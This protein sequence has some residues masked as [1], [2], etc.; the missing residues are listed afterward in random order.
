MVELL[1]KSRVYKIFR[2]YIDFCTRFSFRKIETVGPPPA[3]DGAVVI[4]SNHTNTL[5]DPLVI[6]LPFPDGIVFGARADVFRRPGLA[7]FFHNIKMVPLAR[8]ERELPEEVARNVQTFGEIDKALAH[9]IPFC[10]FP[11]GRHRTMHSLQPMRRGVAGIAF[12]SAAQRPTAIMPVGL[13]YS[14]WFHY[15]GVVRVWYGPLIDVNALA[16]SIAAGEID[17]DGRTAESA[18]DACLQQLLYDKLSELIFFLPDDD[19]YEDRLAEVTAAK[20]LR[21]KFWRILQAIIGFPLFA[22]CAVLSLPMWVPAE[23]LCRWKIKDP[24]FQNTARFGVKMI[25]TP[26]FLIIWAVVFFLLLPWWAAAALLVLFIH[27]Y[28][29]FYDWTGLIRSLRRG[30]GIPLWK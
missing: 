29:V 1:E 7:R 28:S 15:R 14:D 6:M 3:F 9:G 10:L 17:T 24:A 11:E 12:R 5:M 18:R 27:S 22:I 19:K 4:A 13:D 2:P 20:M 8:R 30:E 21:P 25:G 23:C 16:E 26:L